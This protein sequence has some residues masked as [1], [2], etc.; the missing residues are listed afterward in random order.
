MGWLVGWKNRVKI[1]I[2]N[3]TVDAALVDFPVLLQL[4]AASGISAA[5]VTFVFD[6]LL[7]AANRKKIAVTIDDGVTEC[8]VEIEKWDDLNEEAWLWTKVPNVSDVA[9]S[10]VIYLYYDK[11]HPDNDVFVGDIN[12]TPAE[13]VWDTDYVLV[14]HM[15]DATTSTV[16][17]STS[18]H[19][20]GTKKAADEPLLDISGPIGDSQEFDGLPAPDGDYIDCGTGASIKDIEH[21]TIEAWMNAYGWGNSGFGRIWHK[22]S[23]KIWYITDVGGA[24]EGTECLN[25]Y[26]HFSTADGYWHTGNNT[27]VLGTLMYVVV[28]YDDGNVLNDPLMYIDGDPTVVTEGG[29]PVGTHETDVGNG[30]I[31]NRWPQ[32]DRAWDGLLDEI[33][34]SKIIRTAEWID[35]SY[36]SGYDGLLYYGQEESLVPTRLLAPTR[37]LVRDRLVESYLD[38]LQF[39]F[40][41]HEGVGTIVRDLGPFHRDATAYEGASW[42][43]GVMENA[44]AFDGVDGRAYSDAAFPL[45]GTA[46][47][48]VAWVRVHNAIDY[49]T[50]LSDEAQSFTVGFLFCLTDGT[51]WALIW[52]YADGTVFRWG[53]SPAFFVGYAD[54]WVHMGVVVDYAG[55]TIDFY[56]D[57]IWFSTHNMLGVPVF[58]S[59]SRKKILGTYDLAGT[60]YPLKGDMDEVRLFNRALTAPEI[61]QEYYKAARQHY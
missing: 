38:G 19:N 17:D 30:Y 41:F 23:G 20:D 28:T 35:A 40:P 49:Q 25:W 5:D 31:G 52:Q 43:S 2:D 57:G 18:N 42:A 8:Y 33:R 10:T 15:M 22:G 7:V 60:L 21:I 54:T 4:S 6:E 56:R 47:S 9:P 37:L 3:A 46:L 11:N 61:F 51:P 44:L 45:S 29:T 14:C 1:T 59:T 55:K 58:P 12:S 13:N 53:S 32:A 34:I 16:K 24:L 50:F 48:F 27:I 39:Y 36:D 26:Q